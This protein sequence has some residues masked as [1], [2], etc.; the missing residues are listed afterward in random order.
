V[1]SKQVFTSDTAVVHYKSPVT[2]FAFSIRSTAATHMI[3]RLLGG[4][5]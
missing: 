5:G 1:A 2:V 3:N 4:S